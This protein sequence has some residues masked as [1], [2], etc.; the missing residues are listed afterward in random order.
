MS[1][2]VHSHCLSRQKKRDFVDYIAMD[3]SMSFGVNQQRSIVYHAIVALSSS[4][5]YG[6]FRIRVIRIRMAYS[7]VN[8]SSIS[9]SKNAR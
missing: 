8:P 9:A 4:L 7:S 1:L 2:F 3:Q 5:F 6:P